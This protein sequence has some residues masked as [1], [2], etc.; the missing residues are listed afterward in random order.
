MRELSALFGDGRA[1]DEIKRIA[2]DDKAELAYRRA[3]LLTLIDKRP[4][5]LRGICEQLLSVKFLNATAVRGLALFDDRSIGEQLAKSYGRFHP[6]ERG[7]VMDTLASRPSFAGPLLD[8]MAAGRIPRSDLTPFHARQIR[9]FNEALLSER[10][11]S[12]WGA[13]RDSSRGEE[14]IYRQVKNR[15]DLRRAGGGGQRAGEGGLQHGLRSV[16]HALWPRRKVGPDLTGA[17]RDNLDYLLDNIVDP[18]AVVNADFRMSIVAMKDGRTL[19]GLM[20]AKTSR[21][22]T[23]KTM[24]ETMTLERDAIETVRD[25]AVSLMPEGLLESLTENQMPGSRVLFDE[26]DAGAVKVL[27]KSAFDREDSRKPPTCETL[28]SRNEEASAQ[29]TRRSW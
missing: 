9:S 15:I 28:D 7:P 5:D 4:P 13:H 17:G 2:L 11:G 16:S 6:S 14:T 22:I 24:T 18:S 26:P 29:K 25:S 10:L 21:T 20:A 27:F 23:L 3:A 12:V 8:E 1:L 19:N